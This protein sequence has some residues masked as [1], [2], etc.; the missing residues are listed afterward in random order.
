LV[1]AN[2][3]TWDQVAS[4]SEIDR[5][6]RWYGLMASRGMRIDWQTGRVTPP[7]E[8]PPRVPRGQRQ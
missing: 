5:L 3:G 6:T 7:P 1:A 2:F 4:W 8:G